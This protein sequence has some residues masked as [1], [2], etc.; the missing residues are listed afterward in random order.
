MP[1]SL[2]L[3]IQMRKTCAHS[4]HLVWLPFEGE[5]YIYYNSLMEQKL[6]C[7]SVVISFLLCNGKKP[8]FYRIF[9]GDEKWI[10][11]NI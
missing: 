10:V 8:V 11:Y 4:E 3:M 9:T 7:V 2:H 6:N 5:L 1:Q